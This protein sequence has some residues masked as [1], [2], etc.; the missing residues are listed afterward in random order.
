MGKNECLIWC[1]GC[2]Q[3]IFEFDVGGLVCD[4]CCDMYFVV[5]LCFSDVIGSYVFVGGML[6]DFVFCVVQGIVGGGD[7]FGIC[8]QGQQII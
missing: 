3:F 5:Y 1:V 4:F 6:V 2:W 8:C 7:G